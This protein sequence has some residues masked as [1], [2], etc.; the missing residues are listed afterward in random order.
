MELSEILTAADQVEIQ[1][2]AKALTWQDSLT[3]LEKEKTI[4]QDSKWKLAEL[5]Y[6][7]PV[8]QII[9]LFAKAKE[10][11]LKILTQNPYEEYSESLL[12]QLHEQ[13]FTKLE[14]FGNN[15]V[16]T[17]YE[18]AHLEVLDLGWAELKS[19]LQKLQHFHD[20]HKKA[21]AAIDNALFLSWQTNHADFID[22]FSELKERYQHSLMSALGHPNDEN[23]PS[24][25]LYA[26]L[27]EKLY[28]VY[29]TPPNYP[30]SL[31]DG[32]ALEGLSRLSI[33][34]PADFFLLG[35][36][37]E[38]S[39]IEQL[40]F[41]AYEMEKGL[42]VQRKKFMLE[43]KK[44]LEKLGL[45]TITDLKKNQIFSRRSLQEFLTEQ[46]AHRHHEDLDR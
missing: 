9:P 35:L 20:D 30:I 31:E 24:T 14:L 22:K 36:L 39:D 15:V 16:A 34:S 4:P 32:S 45:F 28:S 26:K 44:N 29:W 17:R 10:D 8:E 5:F 7:I 3:F 27:N 21:I 40:D 43:A 1:N 6:N 13:L 2:L 25:G 41:V 37:P 23:Q 38:I 46:L 12:K 11:H 18:I 42:I 19:Y 33:W